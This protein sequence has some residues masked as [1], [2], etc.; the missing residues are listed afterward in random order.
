MPPGNY[1]LTVSITGFATCEATGLRVTVG[2]AAT[3]DAVLKVGAA[4][5][6]VV[7]EAGGATELIT[8]TATVGTTLSA[9]SLLH[10]PNLGRDVSTLAVLQPGV[11]STGYTAG[12]YMDQNTY[13]LDGGN[14][15][16]DMAGNTIGYQTNFTG[17]GGTQT[18]GYASGVVPTPVESIEEVKVSV[19]NQGADFNNST[20]GSIQM[21][22]K[23]GTNVYHGS[24][25]GTTL[26]PTSE[27]RTPGRTTI[28]RSASSALYARCLKTTG[29]A[30]ALRSAGR[31]RRGSSWAGNGTS[32]STTRACDSRTWGPTKDSC[33]RPSCAP[34]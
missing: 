22:T 19:F 20:G 8:T 10:L 14:T 21:A 15:S 17:M 6:T 28:R 23:R 34:A 33:L 2:N 3:V 9:D 26:R 31:L 5:E 7:V 25:Y 12:S 32:S 27:P 24:A 13:I 29:A 16:D 1:K 11:S 30:L 18:G 4:A